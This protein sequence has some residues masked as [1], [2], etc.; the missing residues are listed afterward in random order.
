MRRCVYSAS[1][2]AD[3]HRETVQEVRLAVVAGGLQRVGA[4]RRIAS[5]RDD[6]QR[7]DV[8]APPFVGLAQVIREAQ[9][10]A[11]DLARK[12]HTR[13]LAARIARIVDR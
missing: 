6:L 8:A 5:D 4:P 9:V 1:A 3:L 7:H 2:S 10:L 13:D 11:A 12:R